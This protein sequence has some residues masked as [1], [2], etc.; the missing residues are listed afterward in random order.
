MKTLPIDSVTADTT[1]ASNLKNSAGSII[2]RR[3]AKLSAGMLNRL[4]RMGVESLDVDAADSSELMKERKIMLEALEIRFS[5][6]EGNP[7]LQELKQIAV[8]HLTL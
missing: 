8:R 2:L 4:R 5:G 3:G 7:F 6:T 1:L